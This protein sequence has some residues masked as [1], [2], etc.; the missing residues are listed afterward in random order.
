MYDYGYRIRPGNAVDF[1]RALL[2]GE[3]GKGLFIFDATSLDL[4][5]FQ[6]ERQTYAIEG[7]GRKL[8]GLAESEVSLTIDN[9]TQRQ[10]QSNLTYLSME[11]GEPDAQWTRG[12]IKLRIQA[13]ERPRLLPWVTRQPWHSGSDWK[14]IERDAWATIL[15]RSEAH[16]FSCR[17]PRMVIL[18]NCWPENNLECA[19]FLALSA[20]DG[21]TA[22]YIFS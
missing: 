15:L 5:Q 6:T 7:D 12:T 9:A 22:P 21:L 4:A 20:K 18:P 8:Y 17:I 11:V 10:P 19:E 14:V 13:G 16:S 3:L 1:T 2:N